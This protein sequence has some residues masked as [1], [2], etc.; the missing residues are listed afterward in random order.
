VAARTNH[1]LKTL[2]LLLFLAGACWAGY[3]YLVVR[4]VLGGGEKQV[5]VDAELHDRVRQAVLDEFGEEPAFLELGPLSCRY[6]EG[7]YRLE[8]ISGHGYEREARDLCERISRMIEEDFHLDASVWAYDRA[9]VEI[10]HF[11][12]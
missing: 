6:K 8:F 12:R 5:E 9:S 7:N 3:E 11:V 4:R 10:A 1:P 2:V